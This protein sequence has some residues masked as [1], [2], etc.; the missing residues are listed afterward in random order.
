MYH[1]EVQTD[2][3]GA[4][5]ISSSNAYWEGVWKDGCKKD[6]LDTQSNVSD[7]ST[8]IPNNTSAQDISLIDS[9]I[10]TEIHPTL[11]HP[12]PIKWMPNRT[13]WDWDVDLEDGNQSDDSDSTQTSD[14]SSDNIVDDTVNPVLNQPSKYDPDFAVNLVENWWDPDLNDEKTSVTDFKNVP[15]EEWADFINTPLEINTRERITAWLHRK[16]EYGDVYHE[17][18]VIAKVVRGLRSIPDSSVTSDNSVADVSV[19][20]VKTVIDV[21]IQT[22]AA[23]ID[24]TEK[25]INLMSHFS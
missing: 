6:Q 14:T 17:D 3:T 8:I 24:V 9:P 1:Q 22:D 25:V 13:P 18:S 10:V 5:N 19:Q 4:E 2:G 20:A 15:A 21:G 7:T 16:G 23:V 12:T 11:V